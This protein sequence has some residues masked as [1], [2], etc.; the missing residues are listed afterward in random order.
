LLPV[1]FNFNIQVSSVIKERL[2]GVNNETKQN[3][4]KNE[5]KRIYLV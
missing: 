3:K 4:L 5:R 2:K 1:H